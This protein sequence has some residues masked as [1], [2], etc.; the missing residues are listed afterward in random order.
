MSQTQLFQWENDSFILAK[1]PIEATI[2]NIVDNKKC[3][4]DKFELKTDAL[5]RATC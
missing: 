2:S 4:E 1:A 3:M 5:N